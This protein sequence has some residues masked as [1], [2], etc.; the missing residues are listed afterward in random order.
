ML[1]QKEATIL[2]QAVA[3]WAGLSLLIDPKPNRE[4]MSSGVTW[5]RA[6]ARL[7]GL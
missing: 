4:A 5:C 6:D 3:T 2:A 1:L 7:P